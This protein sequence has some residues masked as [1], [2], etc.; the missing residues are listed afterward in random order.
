M[1]KV[2]HKLE[3]STLA[4]IADTIDLSGKFLK[5][6]IIKEKKLKTVKEL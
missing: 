2:V 4:D 5:I 1:I 3:L 6:V